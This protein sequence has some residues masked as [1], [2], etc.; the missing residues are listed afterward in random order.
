MKL[1]VIS[2]DTYEDS[3]GSMISIFGVYD[4]LEKAKV[5]IEELNDRYLYSINEMELNKTQEI[6]LGGYF[7]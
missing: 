5:A 6:Y 2:A 1:Y 3:W 4:S 7:E